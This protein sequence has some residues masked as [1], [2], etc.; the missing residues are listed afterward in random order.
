MFGEVV[1]FKYPIKATTWT[2]AKQESKYLASTQEKKQRRELI[3]KWHPQ[4]LKVQLECPEEQY[5]R[6][7]LSEDIHSLSKK[8][9]HLKLE[10]RIP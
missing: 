1:P 2:Y 10:D 7:S 9:E 8:S 3:S 5:E 6:A 4:L